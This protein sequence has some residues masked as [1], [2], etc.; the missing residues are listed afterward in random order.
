MGAA[1]GVLALFAVAVPAGDAP[2]TSGPPSAPRP[3]LLALGLEGLGIPA[4]AMRLL[5]GS[6]A[7]ALARNHDVDVVSVADLRRLVELEGERRLLGCSSESCL[8]EVADALGARYVLH[9]QAGT[10]DKSMVLQLSIYDA[11]ASRTASTR[12][13]HA[14]DLEG[15]A[16]AVP[17]TVA[18]LLGDVTG[19][20]PQ[21]ARPTSAPLLWTGGV[22][23]LVGAAV[24]IPAG[25]VALWSNDQL[26]RPGDEVGPAAKEDALGLGRASLALSAVGAAA[27]AGGGALVALAFAE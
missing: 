13:A 6:V 16:R 5:D 18:A 10:L 23:A 15:L 11:E 19:V 27:A 2:T 25:I 9:G 14:A 7:T 20:A 17:G 8:S 1:F 12:Q 21:L 3:R 22:L 26:G 4:D 24:A